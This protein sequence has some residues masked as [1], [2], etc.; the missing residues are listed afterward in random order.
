MRPLNPRERRLLLLCGTGL[1]LL[2]FW[3]LVPGPALHARRAHMTRLNDLDRIAAVLDRVPQPQGAS[4]SMPLPPLRQRVTVAAQAAGIEIRR[5]DPQGSALSVSLG[6][7]GFSVLAGWLDV[8]TSEQAVRIVS[9]EIARRPE[10]GI[11]NARLVL[12]SRR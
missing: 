2:V 6:D 4:V 11:V 5:L 8:L 12:E 7:V 10:P 3:M 9:A 1:S